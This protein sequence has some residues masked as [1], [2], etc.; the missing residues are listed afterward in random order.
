MPFLADEACT[1]ELLVER[2]AAR[3]VRALDGD[4]IDAWHARRR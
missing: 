1:E 3:R 4:V 2:S